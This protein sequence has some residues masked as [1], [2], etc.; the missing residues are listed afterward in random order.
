[1]QDAGPCDDARAAEALV[2]EVD[3]PD[4]EDEIFLL[5]KTTVQTKKLRM[6]EKA[7]KDNLFSK[8]RQA[9]IDK[10][11]WQRVKKNE[12]DAS[13]VCPTRMLRRW[14]QTPDRRSTLPLY[15]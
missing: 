10:E 6:I 15:S 12:V 7:M 13:N 5:N 11:A 4:I 14:L 2:L 3:V 1:M 8:A 9:Q